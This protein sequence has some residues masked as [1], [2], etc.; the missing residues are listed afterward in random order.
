MK[1]QNR[2]TW[3]AP[4]AAITGDGRLEAQKDFTT[5]IHAFALVRRSRPVR[6]LIRAK[7]T[8]GRNRMTAAAWCGTWGCPVSLNPYPYMARRA[9]LLGSLPGV[10]IEALCGGPLIGGLPKG[11][12]RYP[13]SGR[14]GYDAGGRRPSSGG[15]RCANGRLQNWQPFE[16]ETVVNQYEDA[17]LG[18]LCGDGACVWTWPE[19]AP[20][21]ELYVH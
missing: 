18:D 11:R 14:Y 19:P 6:L 7:A 2:C 15:D 21:E 9:G 1:A 13:V 3:F 5:L 12:R 10:L 17:L 16:L 20:T 8:K 4:G